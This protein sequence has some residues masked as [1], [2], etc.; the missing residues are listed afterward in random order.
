[1]LNKTFK[2][3]KKRDL[4]VGFI[5]SLGQG[6]GALLTK[7]I[8][9]Q[10]FLGALLGVVGA[11]IGYYLFSLIKDKQIEIN[12]IMWIKI[13]LYFF[14]GIGIL[15]FGY[16]FLIGANHFIKAYDFMNL[17]E[18]FWII[19]FGGLP[20]TFFIIL[21]FI[22]GTSSIYFKPISELKMYLIGEN[23]ETH[24]TPAW[25]GIKLLIFIFLICINPGTI[26]DWIFSA[27]DN[28]F[29]TPKVVSVT[30]KIGENW[31]LGVK[32]F[33]SLIGLGLLSSVD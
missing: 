25:Y 2:N 23:I 5:S 29:E 12:R 18:H 26:L 7:N 8:Y 21:M 17:S 28:I 3:F 13:T 22:T 9:L 11:V 10:I 19:I 33:Y 31:S 32:I 30:S 6:G 16:I 15:F 24:N 20:M 27:G 14:I 1:M 4:I